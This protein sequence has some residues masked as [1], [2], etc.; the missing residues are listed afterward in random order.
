MGDKR[1]GAGSWAGSTATC[2]GKVELRRPYPQDPETQCFLVRS[3]I[4][5]M[6]NILPHTLYNQATN[7]QRQQNT[8]GRDTGEEKEWTK[9]PTLRHSTKEELI[10]TLNRHCFCKS[11][12]TQIEA[13]GGTQ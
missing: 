3:L 4:K 2:E 8:A 7:L 6:R 11:T 1:E 10:I 9:R 13:C 5:I 12:P